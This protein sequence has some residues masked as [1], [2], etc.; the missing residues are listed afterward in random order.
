MLITF[1]SGV[2]EITEYCFDRST[3][4]KSQVTVVH[5]FAAPVG[6]PTTSSAVAGSP[7]VAEPVVA[8]TST[9]S[10]ISEL[11]ALLKTLALIVLRPSAKAI[12][13]TCK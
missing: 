8:S 3:A 4:P 7:R 10:L 13:F 5:P 12:G 2:I 9:L 11:A 1:A 6:V